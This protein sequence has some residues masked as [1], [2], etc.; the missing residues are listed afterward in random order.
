MIQA[1]Q[2]VYAGALGLLVLLAGC[3]GAP[4]RRTNTRP[5]AIIVSPKDGSTVM[6]GESVALA[7]DARDQQEPAARLQYQW[8][9]DAIRAD[10]SRRRVLSLR[11]IKTAFEPPTTTVDHYEVR[12]IVTDSGMLRDTVHVRLAAIPRPAKPVASAT[13]SR[14]ATTPVAPRI[15]NHTA[16]EKPSHTAKAPVRTASAGSKPKGS[17]PAPAATASADGGHTVSSPTAQPSL[18]ARSATAVQVPPPATVD[19]APPPATTTA[20]SPASSRDSGA[21]KPNPPSPPPVAPQTQPAP[22]EASY[23]LGP[24][25]EVHVAIYAGGEKQE[26]FSGNVAPSGTLT[27][28]LIG[29]I[30]VS[31]LTASE[32]S[33]RIR[34][35][36]ARDYFVNPQVMVS[37]ASFARKVYVSGEV[38]NPGGYSVATGLTVMSVCTLAGG[39]TD[40]ASLKSVKLIRTENGRTRTIDIDLSKV[41]RGKAPDLAVMAG[42][43]IDVPHRRY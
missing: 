33:N 19:A 4:V 21:A 32:V 30:P 27:S 8:D 18:A 1:R 3:A 34:E 38:R 36:L 39:F 35:I 29:E 16:P 11:G 12:L 17:G 26:D 42:D 14:S 31:G 22:D 9:V 2:A 13:A 5:E 15:G 23:P 43:R 28:P 10:H 41:R 25:D 7:A 40:F 37:V 24:G 6:A 20:A